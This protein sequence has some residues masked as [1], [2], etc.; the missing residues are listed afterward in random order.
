VPQ[1]TAHLPKRPTPY[2]D[3]IFRR[4]EIKDPPHQIA[5]MMPNFFVEPILSPRGNLVGTRRM[6]EPYHSIYLLWLSRYSLADMWVVSGASYLPGRF[7]LTDRNDSR[8]R[9]KLPA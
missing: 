6:D 5:G 1:K 7:A 8:T 4:Y 3:T 2:S 9:E